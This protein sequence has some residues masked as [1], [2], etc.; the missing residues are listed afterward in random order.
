MSWVPR[1]SLPIQQKDP[2]AGALVML[3]KKKK[4]EKT[5][6]VAPFVRSSAVGIIS[7][8]LKRLQMFHKMSGKKNNET[9]IR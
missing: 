3:P 6:I 4:K 5:K 1:W 8:I 7:Q 9:D 2:G